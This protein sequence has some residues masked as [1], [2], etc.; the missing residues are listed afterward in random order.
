MKRGSGEGERISI[1]KAPTVCLALHLQALSDAQSSL[2]SNSCAFHFPDPKRKEGE[3]G[4]GHV[5]GRVAGQGVSGAGRKT[6]W[7]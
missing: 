4:Q 6:S 2:E 7:L 3:R 1:F 5:S